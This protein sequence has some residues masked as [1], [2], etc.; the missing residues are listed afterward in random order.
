MALLR[1]QPWA[2]RT[3]TLLLLLWHTAGST[4]T[5]NATASPHA[6]THYV[7]YQ[8]AVLVLGTG[9]SALPMERVDDAE[10]S[11]RQTVALRLGS[12]HEHTL[13]TTT[14]ATAAACRFGSTSCRAGGETP[15]NHAASLAPALLRPRIH[16]GIDQEAGILW[17]TV[18]L[19]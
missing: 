9:K 15:L 6:H 4:A 16:V 5:A 3:S 14:I 2:R 8:G 11:T 10:A 17:H 12:V 18:C 7:D 13:G 1:L 19:T